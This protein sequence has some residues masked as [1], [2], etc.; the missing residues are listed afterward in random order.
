MAE[1]KIAVRL[2]EMSSDAGYVP[3]SGYT[4]AILTTAEW[5]ADC[6]SDEE[7]LW[8]VEGM[9][10]TA[11]MLDEV[12][13]SSYKNGACNYIEWNGVFELL[14]GAAVI[15]YTR[16]DIST[17]KSI[18]RKAWIVAEDSLLNLY[19]E[20]VKKY[21]ELVERFLKR[22]ASFSDLREAVEAATP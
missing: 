22:K 16:E 4:E 10:I 12:Q 6:A 9:L 20:R 17:A 2:M 5:A 18:W 3:S 7:A 11:E 1:K 19:K 15:Q 14:P 8:D 13:V 21:Q